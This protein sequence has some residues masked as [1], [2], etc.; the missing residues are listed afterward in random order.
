M[1]QSGPALP[2]IFLSHGAPTLVFE[3]IPAR[4]FMAGLAATL[5]R[6][7]AILCIS[8]HW[9]TKRPAVSGA[10][11]PETIH[12]F[13]GFPDALYRLHYTAPGAPDLARRAAKL[14]KGMEID[15]G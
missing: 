10:E 11:N 1:S 3:E 6:P 9:E 14:V 7:E 4:H 8:A 12:D 5:P 15:P 2:A 13:Y